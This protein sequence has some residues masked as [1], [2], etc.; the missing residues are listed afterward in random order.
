MKRLYIGSLCSLYTYDTGS[1]YSLYVITLNYVINISS[2]AIWPQSHSPSPCVSFST[3][4]L[5][6]GDPAVQHI[7]PWPTFEL[8]TS[9]TA[10]PT[11]AAK[12]LRQEL[13]GLK[14]ASKR[15]EKYRAERAQDRRSAREINRQSSGERRHAAGSFTDRST[16]GARH[17]PPRHR[18]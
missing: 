16:R 1:L 17:G 13:T 3:Q 6:T 14:H 18:Q 7:S 5:Q 9:I 8:A 12:A 10:P 2:C 11:A 15:F 4:I